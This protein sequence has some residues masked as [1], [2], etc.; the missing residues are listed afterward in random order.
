MEER[1][2]PQ[3]AALT[4]AFWGVFGGFLAVG[5]N[6]IPERIGFGDLARIA[7]ST[8]KISRVI[9]KD[10]IAAFIRA[11]VTDDAAAQEPKQE[12]MA[13]AVGALVTCPY[14]IGLWV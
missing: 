9:T 10:E 8:Y 4:A 3:Y 7:L 14:C 13:A 11:P 2:L 12:G 6:R 1:P 5:R